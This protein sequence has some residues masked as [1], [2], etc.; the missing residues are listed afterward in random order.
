MRNRTRTKQ[1]IS[2]ISA[3]VFPRKPG[4]DRKQHACS[5]TATPPLEPSG[6]CRRQPSWVYLPRNQ[7]A[8]ER[9]L[10]RGKAAHG[11]PWGSSL[12]PKSPLSQSTVTESRARQ[13]TIILASPGVQMKRNIKIS[14][15][16]C[17]PRLHL[18]CSLCFLWFLVTS[19]DTNELI[20]MCLESCLLLVWVWVQFNFFLQVNKI[21]LKENGAVL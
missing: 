4:Q 1:P 16:V 10:G 8:A 15:L 21:T 20:L 11:H 2:S 14:L 5:S 12:R 9:M 17:R 7:E 19:I 18:V 13:Y 3:N 6:P